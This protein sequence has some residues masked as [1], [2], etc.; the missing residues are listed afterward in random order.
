MPDKPTINQAETFR[1][2]LVQLC[3][4]R[5]VAPSVEQATYLIRLAHADGASY[6]LTPETTNVMELNRA[7]LRDMISHEA[8]CRILAHFKALASELGIWLHLGSMTFRRDGGKIANRSLLITPDG[9]IAAHYDKIHMFDVDLAGGESY[10]ES[11]TFEAG[12]RAVVAAL[13]WG[14]I[15]LTICYDLRFPALYRALAHAGAD[16]LA[17]P[18]AFTKQTGRAHWRTLLR[19]RAIENGC[20]IFAAAQGGTHETGRETYGH[21]L[22]VDPWGVVL[23]EAGVEPGVISA[24][25]DPPRVGE[26]RRRIPSLMHDR[27]FAGSDAT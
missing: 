25:I 9:A 27:V 6:V 19:A 21:S 8:D 5:T 3:S 17:V 14:R 7:R 1:A 13:P 2:A 10:R 11:K 23:A 16:F 12:T 24:E 4:A 26:A 20:F 15:G 22:I 18:S